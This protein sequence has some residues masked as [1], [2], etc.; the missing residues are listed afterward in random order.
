L[1]EMII[2][3]RGMAQSVKRNPDD[4][5]LI[6]LAN[7]DVASKPLEKDRSTFTGNFEQIKRDIEA[8]RAIGIEELII[9]SIFSRDSQNE[10]G[11]L[12]NLEQIRNLL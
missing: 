7:I 3:L 2:Q 6:L 8:A 5:K 9:D 11:L 10:D 4:L 1:K 12:R